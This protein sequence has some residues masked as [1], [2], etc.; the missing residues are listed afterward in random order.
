MEYDMD[1]TLIEW[2]FNALAYLAG[3]SLATCVGTALVM[4]HLPEPNYMIRWIEVCLC[5]IATAVLW[6]RTYQAVELLIEA[7][8]IEKEIVNR[9]ESGVEYA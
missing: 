3:M 2:H 1:R 5:W 7:H 4:G 8:R 9:K 6:R